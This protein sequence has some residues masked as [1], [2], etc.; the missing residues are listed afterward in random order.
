MIEC[1]FFIKSCFYNGLFSVR[2]LRLDANKRHTCY[3]DFML[4]FKRRRVLSENLKGESGV[5]TG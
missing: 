5:D 1:H 3:W 2:M 4:I